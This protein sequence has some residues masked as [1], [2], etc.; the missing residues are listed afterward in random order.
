M[1]NFENIDMFDM[2]GMGEVEEKKDS[3]KVET[4]NKK[5]EKNNKTTTE[6][7]TTAN[8]KANA[9]NKAKA[10]K[11]QEVQKSPNE[12]IEDKLKNYQRVQLK[13]YAQIIH[14]FEDAEEIKNLKLE[15]VRTQYLQDHVEFG[16]NTKWFLAEVPNDNTIACLVPISP[17]YAKG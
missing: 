3:T 4:T 15:D 11:E 9:K 16:E 2:F 6:A 8:K 17:F 10:Q 14:T 7:K 1:S 5:V 13:V 12:E